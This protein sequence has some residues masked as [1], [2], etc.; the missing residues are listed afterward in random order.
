MRSGYSLRRCGST[1]RLVQAYPLGLAASGSTYPHP[2]PKPHPHPHLICIYI[3]HRVPSC[4]PTWQDGVS[5]RRC[6]R[7]ADTASSSP[8][9]LGTRPRH[10]YTYYYGETYYDD[11]YYYG[12]GNYYGC[13][14][15]YGDT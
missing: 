2:H 14:S 9:R 10:R 13:R 7:M 4:S 15:Y 5:C 11:A 6:A 8:T 1:G 12:G 3:Y